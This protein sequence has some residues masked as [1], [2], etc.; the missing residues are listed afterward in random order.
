MS[1]GIKIHIDGLKQIKSE[2]RKKVDKRLIMLKEEIVNNTTPLVPLGT[3]ALR[4]SVKASVRDNDNRIIWNSPYAHFLHEG[5]V[6]IG[7]RSHSPWARYGEKKVKTNRKLTYRHGGANWVT[8]S[9]KVNG[10]HW[11]EFVA[12]LGDM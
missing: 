3:G 4:N 10:K 6:M 5:Y 7:E 2:T 1:A 11:V 8:E 9:A 12:K